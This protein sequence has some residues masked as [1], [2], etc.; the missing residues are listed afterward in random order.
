MA[1]NCGDEMRKLERA[2]SSAASA[3]ED[4]AGRIREVANVAILEI[5]MRKAK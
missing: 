5:G 3:L 1:V 4:G 2:D